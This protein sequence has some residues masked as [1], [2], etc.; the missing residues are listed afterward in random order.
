MSGV[1]LA[2]DCIP[3]S[4][5]SKNS[6]LREVFKASWRDWPIGVVDAAS[7]L[8]RI[9]APHFNGGSFFAGEVIDLVFLCISVA[10]IILL[11]GELWLWDRTLLD[12]NSAASHQRFSVI[13][14]V[15]AKHENSWLIILSFSEVRN[16]HPGTAFCYASVSEG[17]GQSVVAPGWRQNCQPF[18]VI[19]MKP[20]LKNDHSVADVLSKGI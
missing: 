5:K 13:G 6:Y 14:N 16:E 1:F 20:S 17:F 4:S 8:I 2:F 15:I 7:S 3:V 12:I 9:Y 11:P 18:I 10:L 19:H